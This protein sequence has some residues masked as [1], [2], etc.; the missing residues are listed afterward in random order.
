MHVACAMILH[1]A[2]PS[3]L[4]SPTAKYLPTYPF[5][6]TDVPNNI[7]VVDPSGLPVAFHRMDNAC[8]GLIDISIKK[9]RTSVLF[10]GLPT[11]SVYG[12]AHPGAPFYGIEQT[13]AGLIVRGGG[14]PIYLE[15]KL[16]VGV[17]VSGG[18][19]EQDVNIATAGVLGLG[20]STSDL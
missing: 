11:E 6:V 12:L 8:P 4:Y 13:D 17:G 9:A 10:N 15:G 18:S 16:I 3:K 19:A 14:V 1:V 2:K 5:P 20:A 7:A